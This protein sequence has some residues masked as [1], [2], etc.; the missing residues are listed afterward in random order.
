[1]TELFFEPYEIPA[2]DLGGENPLPVFRGDKDDLE[3]QLADNVP[4]E[5]RR[6][7]GCALADRVLPYCMQDGYTRVRRPRAFRTL[8]LENERLRARFAP[9]LGGRLL[10]LTALPRGGRPGGCAAPGPA[11]PHRW[12]CRRATG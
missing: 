9:E 2:A 1:M 3:I 11:W 10:S 6:R 7:I 12:R 4:E 8:I 5:E